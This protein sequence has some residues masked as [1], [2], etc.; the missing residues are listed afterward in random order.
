MAA[1]GTA[2]SRSSALP[3]RLSAT[4][5]RAEL[6]PGWVGVLLGP[7]AARL[8]SRAGPVAVCA[9]ESAAFT[10]VSV[11]VADAAAMDGASFER[12]T[13]EAYAAV[14]DILGTRPPRHAVRLWN[15]IPRL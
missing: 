14:A 9:R 6:A 4:V 7:K 12:Y 13:A 5:V 15:H 3:S 8:E 10:L 2:G 1:P 11:R